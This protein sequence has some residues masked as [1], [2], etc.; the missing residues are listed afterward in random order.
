MSAMLCFAACRHV[1]D[2]ACFSSPY[3]DCRQRPSFPPPDATYAMSAADFA[4]FFADM[5]PCRCH[6]AFDVSFGHFFR[7]LRRT[8]RRR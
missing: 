8:D 5:L 1:P 7:F 6:A 4:S 3:A 2:A